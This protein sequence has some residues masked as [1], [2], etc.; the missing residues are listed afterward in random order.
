MG[1]RRSESPRNHIQ[2][3]RNLGSLVLNFCPNVRYN[4][5][6]GRSGICFLHGPFSSKLRVET[7]EN[8]CQ[9][10]IFRKFAL[11]SASIIPATHA[12]FQMRFC[13]TAQTPTAA[14]RLARHTRHL[15]LTV[16]PRFSA[17]I[18][19]EAKQKNKSPN[20]RARARAHKFRDQSL[21]FKTPPQ[22]PAPSSVSSKT[23]L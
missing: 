6:A 21:K 8:R 13:A 5:G 14:Y 16:F 3:A 12:I 17:R 20:S 2:T 11:R 19:Q 15:C 18:A 1:A 7:P 10:E 9:A 4:N 23:R 22:A